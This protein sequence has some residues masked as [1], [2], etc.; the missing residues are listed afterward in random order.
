MPSYEELERERV[1]RDEVIP[2]ELAYLARNLRS[3]FQLST[4]AVGVKGD[5]RH[6]KGYHRSRAWLLNSRYAT[7][8][9]YS[10]TETDWNRT[11]GN[12]NWVCAI[13]IT[14]PEKTLIAVCKRL[15]VAVRAGQLEK[16]AEWYGNKDGDKR[17]DGYD[18]I[19]NEIASSDSSHLWHLHISFIRGHA[20]D[21]HAD[22]F[23]VLTGQGWEPPKVPTPPKP[24]ADMEWTEAL[25][26]NLPILNMG[27][28]GAHVR[29]AQGLLCARG[30]KVDIDGS[31][32]PDTRAKTLAM[33][34]QYG[35]EDVDGSWGPETWTI[36][37]T[38]ADSANPAR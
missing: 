37:I 19:E 27:A 5:N 33:Q 36:A 34:K 7:N 1:Y 30:Y 31:F 20:N 6:L 2:V 14:L 29:T 32:G 13:D 28:T 38:L 9:S 16:V 3:H 4:N 22:V 10:V 18:N 26:R 11:R 12:S 24:P 8:R 35:A 17:V 25:M 23:A 15:D 21:N